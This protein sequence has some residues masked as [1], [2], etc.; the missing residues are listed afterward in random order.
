MRRILLLLLNS[1]LAFRRSLSLQTPIILKCRSAHNRPPFSHEI[2]RHAV[3]S[4]DETDRR[5]KS[6]IENEF[7]HQGEQTSRHLSN[8]A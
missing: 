6:S 8:A 1:I 7:V 2:F 5:R 3:L 4:G